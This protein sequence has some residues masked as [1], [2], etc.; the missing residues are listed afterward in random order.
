[1][2][3]ILRQYLNTTVTLWLASYFSFLFF[4]SDTFPSILIT[5]AVY[6]LLN[7]ILKPA[8]KVIFMPINLITLGFLSWVPTVLIL[9]ITNLFVS[10]FSVLPFTTSSFTFIGINLPPLN[11][12][13]ISAH[14][15]A[16]AIFALIR[17]LIV[18]IYKKPEK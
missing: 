11:F 17:R 14:I 3:K 16:A 12:G 13:F 9:Y 5:S 8:L 6:T 15:I 10:D 2:K 18:W 1:M 7:L 4:F